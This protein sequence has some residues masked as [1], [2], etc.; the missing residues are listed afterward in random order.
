MSSDT[1]QLAFDGCPGSDCNFPTAT[2]AGAFVGP[3]TATQ[4]QIL[5]HIDRHGSIRSVEAGV[6]IHRARGD[7]QFALHVKQHGTERLLT[8]GS[9]RV[10][11]TLGI[12]CCQ[13]AATDGLA[14]MKRLMKRGIVERGPVKG[15]WIRC[16][17]PAP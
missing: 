10:R 17:R 9:W 2:R 4:R 12:G 3:L 11:T 8:S 16:V 15:T 7:L 13:Y 6:I 5:A 14:G 1:V